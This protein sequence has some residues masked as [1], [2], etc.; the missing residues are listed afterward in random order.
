MRFLKSLAVTLLLIMGNV[1]FL[2]AQ[3]R[4]VS[5][6]VLDAQNYPVIGAAVMLAGGGN[7]GTVTDL[8]G[9]F[10]IDVPSGE[11]TVSVT[12]PV[13]EPPVVKSPE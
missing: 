13:A 4:G 6:T 12:V 2:H 9:A 3:S 11:V 1:S 5:G 10:Q 7:V 8:D